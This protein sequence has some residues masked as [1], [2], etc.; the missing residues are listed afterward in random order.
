MDGKTV[1]TRTDTSCYNGQS[2]CRQCNPE[3]KYSG[4]IN[5]SCMMV[6]FKELDG[7]YCQECA[8]K[9]ENGDI[10]TEMRKEMTI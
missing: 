1:L 10:P 5:W 7:F 3:G 2:P 8:K 9:M 4:Y 6:K